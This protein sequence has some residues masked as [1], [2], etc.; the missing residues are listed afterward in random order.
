MKES[1]NSNSESD[2]DATLVDEES[3][4]DKDKK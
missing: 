2:S 3:F 1:K 4:E